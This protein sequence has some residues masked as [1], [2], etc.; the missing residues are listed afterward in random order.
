MR[1]LGR[2]SAAITVVNALPTGVGC[3]VG[4]GLFATADVHVR[5]TRKL[6]RPSLDIPPEARTPVVE[7]ALRA[8]LARFFPSTP[9][10]AS[11][12][13]RSD[14]PA[15]RGLKSSSAVACA[16]L[17]AV[18][19]AAG[20]SVPSIEIARISAEVSRQTGVS[21]T[22]ALDDA[23]AGLTSGFVLTDNVRGIL[24]KEGP[25]DPDWEAALFIPPTPHRPSPEWSAAF[26]ARA[27]EG[28]AAVEAAREG[29]WWTA[30]E[31]NTELV[32]SVM[33][34]RYDEVRARLRAAGA[35]AA[36]VSGL[37]PT[38]AAVAPADRVDA[39][40]ELFPAAEGLRRRVALSPSP[41]LSAG[42]AA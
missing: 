3:A 15:A 22:G 19:H 42:G 27:A 25:V 12:V 13:L 14:I 10:D 31:R 30:M 23:L 16:V 41:E 7:E 17:D 11:L 34:Y 40:L 28:A 20:A 38:L 29:D 39:I 9:S 21:A 6:H 1:G 4:V 33:G 2:A 24:L 35:L 37:G 32:E 26:R 5:P 36:G 8:G 18:A